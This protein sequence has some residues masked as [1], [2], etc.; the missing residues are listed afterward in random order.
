MPKPVKQ[1]NH[2]HLRYRPWP[3]LSPPSSSRGMSK[4]SCS[5]SSWPTPLVVEM[6]LEMSQLKLRPSMES[7]WLLIRRSLPKR[8]S[9]WRSITGFVR[10]SPSLGSYT[11]QS[12]RRPSSLCS[13]YG[14]MLAR[15]GPITPPLALRTI[16]FCGPSSVMPSMPLTS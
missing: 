4:P 15:G 8:E 10:S 9:L 11:A 12:T 6:G 5:D 16:K 2:T 1:M 14:E 13:S 7:L 3:K